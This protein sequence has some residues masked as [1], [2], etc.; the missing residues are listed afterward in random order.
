MKYIWWGMMGTKNL[1]FVIEFQLK[2]L[3]I[4]FNV[5]CNNSWDIL[6]EKFVK[7]IFLTTALGKKK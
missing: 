5:V 3:R 4:K 7:H 6:G 1:V 2:T